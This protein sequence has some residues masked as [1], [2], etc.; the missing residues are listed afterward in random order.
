MQHKIYRKRQLYCDFQLVWHFLSSPQNLSKNTPREMK[1]AVLS[2]H[3]NGGMVIHYMPLP[4]LKIPLKWKTRKTH[5]EINKSFTA[6]QEKVPHKYRKHFHEFIP[7]NNG[8]LMK[9]TVDYELTLGIRGR[10]MYWIVLRK[11]LA[12]ILD[13]RFRGLESL[14]N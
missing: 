1:F 5:V 3:N 2:D 4:L 8:E 9:D 13:Y 14:F 10:P 12:G 7:N 11:K 6:I